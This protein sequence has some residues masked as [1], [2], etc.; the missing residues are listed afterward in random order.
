MSI[1]AFNLVSACFMAFMCAMTIFS[2]KEFMEGG[3]SNVPWFRDIPND[4]RHRLYYTSIFLSIVCL[5]GG[6]VPAIVSP[7]SGLLCLQNTV[8]YFANLAHVVLFLGSKAYGEVRPKGYTASF[9]QWTGMSAL[10]AGLGIWGIAVYSDAG[11]QASG[12]FSTLVFDGPISVTTANIV[13]VAFSSVFGFQFA[14]MPQ[15]LLSAFWD[16]A[17]TVP[18]QTFFG[19]PV[20]KAHQGELFW[21]RN[22]GI[23]ILSLNACGL[24]HGI[25]NP[26]LT[27]QLLL[28]TSVLTLFNLNQLIMEP[29][30]T[31]TLRHIQIS[32][33]P[34][35]LLCGGSIAVSALALS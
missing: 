9:Y 22:T 13:G 28:I 1:F 32:W 31:K 29:Y 2:P 16:D 21:A 8:L 23:T 34:T 17:E 4:R 27:L 24:A 10:T 15:R 12:W 30:G 3:I 25:S 18:N 7:Q 20:I 35:L 14:L 5:F 33:I 11:A 19:F 26:L 6:V